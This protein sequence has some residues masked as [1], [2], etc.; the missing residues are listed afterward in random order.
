ML[1]FEPDAAMRMVGAMETD[2]FTKAT[3]LEDYSAKLGNAVNFMKQNWQQMQIQQ[4]NIAQMRP[5]FQQQQQQFRPVGAQIQAHQIQQNYVQKVN[6]EISSL[7]QAFT[8]LK[9]ELGSPDPAIERKIMDALSKFK[10]TK[11]EPILK[12]S[13]SEKLW[14]KEIVLLLASGLFLI[15]CPF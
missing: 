1:P 9:K 8:T 3:S 5:Q 2:S 15:S 10:K 14:L 13:D 4:I 12:L 11:P 6:Q 7:I